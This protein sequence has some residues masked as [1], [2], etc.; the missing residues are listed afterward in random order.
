MITPMNPYLFVLLM[1]VKQYEPKAGL[2]TVISRMLPFV[3]PFWV[4]WV[5]VLV[6]VLVVFYF[7][8]WPMGPGVGIRIGG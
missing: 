2:G 6:L 7:A 3:I 4:A 8:G 5:L 1:L